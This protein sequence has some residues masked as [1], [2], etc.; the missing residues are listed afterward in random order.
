[1]DISFYE[2]NF[3]FLFTNIFVV[4]IFLF[5]YHKVKEWFVGSMIIGKT[6]Q[7]IGILFLDLGISTNQDKFHFLIEDIMIIGIGFELFGIISFHGNFIKRNLIIVF[8]TT[9]LLVVI[10][11][12]TSFLIAVKVN[13]IVIA[14]FLLYGY[15]GFYLILVSVPSRFKYIIGGTFILFALANLFQTS[16]FNKKIEA[17]PAFNDQMIDNRPLMENPG[18]PAPPNLPPPD[19]IRPK[20]PGFMPVYS[21][22]VYLVM[23]ISGFGFL[24]LLKEQDEL[25]LEI[26]NNSISKENKD[27]KKIDEERNRFFSIISHD[28]RNPIGSV[29]NLSS[30][31]VSK[32][33]QLQKHEYEKWIELINQSLARTYTLL[34]NLLQWAR[35][36]SGKIS[37]VPEPLNVKEIVSNVIELLLSIAKDK[38]IS[39]ENNCNEE[40]LVLADKDMMHTIMRNLLS[41]ALKFTSHKGV[42][43]I[44]TL[45]EDKRIIIVVKDNGI[46]IS[47]KV[48][49]KLFRLD[50]H[51]TT[52]GTDKESGSG[53]G[54]KIC[55]EFVAMNKG[56]IWVE[57]KQGKGSSF[58]VS[59]PIAE[60]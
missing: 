25:S 50:S 17:P 30:M 27:L 59:L 14:S 43:S 54:L 33:E 11:F 35:S 60:K 10:S 18:I 38:E 8:A 46:G 44:S 7:I 53:L 13:Y 6:I 56:A 37:P 28:L 39:I 21:D 49:D 57:S 23:I 22:I 19:G 58:Y 32:K 2:I 4:V 55:S 16:Q 52:I 29:A 36:Q 3:T 15:S 5:H 24:I 26:L 9:S 34:N 48:S 1:M 47:K 20:Q 51:Y 45:N 41:N 40:E 42:V 12:I 31:L